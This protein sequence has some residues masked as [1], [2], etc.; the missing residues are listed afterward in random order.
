MAKQYITAAEIAE[1]VGGS[2]ST[3]YRII[4]ELN[5]ERK[6]NGYITVT[7]RVPRVFFEEKAYGV[8][9]GGD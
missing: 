4:R 7:G 9:V 5:A 6:E 3:G 2:K 1:I 8:K